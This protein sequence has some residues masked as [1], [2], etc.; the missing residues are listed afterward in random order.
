[1]TD[2]T[3]II[4]DTPGLSNDIA[5]WQEV[6]TAVERELGTDSLVYLEASDLDTEHHT[7][8]VGQCLGTIA[9]QDGT[10]AGLDISIWSGEKAPPRT[11]CITR[12]EADE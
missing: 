12:V 11:Y 3:D 1:M 5:M 6:V 7:D 2:L 10:V 9:R 4:D 8:R